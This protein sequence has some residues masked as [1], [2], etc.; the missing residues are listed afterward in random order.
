MEEKEIYQLPAEGKMHE[1][2]EELYREYYKHTRREK[3]LKERDKAHHVYHY[4]SLDSD[5]IL[6]EEMF[7]Y[8]EDEGVEDQ[9]I[10]RMQLAFMLQCVSELPE[11]DQLLILALF[12]QSKTER[13]Y[14]DELGLSQKTVNNLK[15]RVLEKIRKKMNIL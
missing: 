11:E 1:V 2:T 3:Y 10:H 14:A 5:E 9:V 12:Y 6:G 4:S 13:E 8:P 15:N 7:S